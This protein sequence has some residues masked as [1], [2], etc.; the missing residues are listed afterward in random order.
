M[1]LLTASGTEGKKAHTIS[2]SLQTAARSC[3]DLWS[4]VIGSDFISQVSRITVEARPRMVTPRDDGRANEVKT[5]NKMKKVCDRKK[6]RM[7]E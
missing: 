2:V 5:Q 4:S 7:Q 6:G 3:S 1:A